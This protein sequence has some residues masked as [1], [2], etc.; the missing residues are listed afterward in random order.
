MITDI[1]E[2]ERLA[3]EKSEIS[4]NM[5]QAKYSG[6]QDELEHIEN[7]FKRVEAMKVNKIR[8]SYVDHDLFANKDATVSAIG[9]EIMDEGDGAIRTV[10][11]KVLDKFWRYYKT[12][13]VGT[14]TEEKVIDALKNQLFAVQLEIKQA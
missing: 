4:H 3:L 5:G 8:V 2:L 9:H 6:A 10:A 7:L 12:A 11:K 1:E 14:N 13:D